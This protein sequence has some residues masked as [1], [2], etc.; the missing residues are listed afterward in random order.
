MIRWADRMPAEEGAR[1]PEPARVPDTAAARPPPA[2]TCGREA[3]RQRTGQLARADEAHAHGRGDGLGTAR[4]LHE[5]GP[6]EPPAVGARSGSR[7]RGA[8]GGLGT[9][10]HCLR[11]D[12]APRLGRAANQF[13]R[14]SL[15]GAGIREKPILERTN[16]RP[17]ARAVCPP[18]EPGIGASEPPE[19]RPEVVVSNYPVR[20]GPTPDVRGV[21]ARVRPKSGLCCAWGVASAAA[22]GGGRP[23]VTGMNGAGIVPARCGSPAGTCTAPRNWFQN[24]P[25]GLLSG[26]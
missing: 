11:A 9:P 13:P 19:R 4:E 15:R 24:T 14:S 12:G 6:T 26:A 5:A 2:L 23:R 18:L 3:P 16:P 21:R 1:Q 20:R 22:V 7:T 8:S 10:P 17:G 25:D